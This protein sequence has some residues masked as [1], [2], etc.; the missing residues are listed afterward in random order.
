[1]TQKEG[2]QTKKGAP[3]CVVSPVATKPSIN[4][5][6]LKYTAREYC[7]KSRTVPKVPCGCFPHNHMMAHLFDNNP[8][9]SVTAAESITLR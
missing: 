6:K 4:F 8:L 1:M 2:F 3:E 5:I 7:N 9:G